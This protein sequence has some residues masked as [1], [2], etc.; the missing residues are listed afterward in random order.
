[1]PTRASRGQSQRRF[2]PG[3]FRGFS[4]LGLPRPRLQLSPFQA[5]RAS[6]VEEGARP[7]QGMPST[8]SPGQSQRR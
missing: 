2:L 5:F 3:H 1:M 4:A 7:P 8:A 6:G